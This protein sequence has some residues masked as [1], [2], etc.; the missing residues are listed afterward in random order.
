MDLIDMNQ[1]KNYNQQYRYILT[2]VDE[3]SKYVI[4][5]ELK[6]KEQNAVLKAFKE[7]CE[8]YGYP[9]STVTDNGLEL[10]II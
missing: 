5:K 1:I 6:N 10:K 9:R 2:I 7:A 8:E 3:F 4:L